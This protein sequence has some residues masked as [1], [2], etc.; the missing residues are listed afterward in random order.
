M[1]A[2]YA[3]GTVDASGRATAEAIM[4]AVGSVVWVDS[5]DDIDS[6]TAVSGSG[7]AYFLRLIEL[8]AEA[9]TGL[10]LAPQVAGQLA[11]ET[12]LGTARL[13]QGSERSCAQLRAEVTSAGGTTAA[14]L[15]VM[16][17]ADLHGIVQAAVAAAKRRAGELAA[18]FGAD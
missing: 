10:G 4:R 18:E 9:G 14:A 13:A 3:R 16:E 1:T 2:L 5:D 12:A 11:I 7:P 6:V 8:I 17:A 15:A